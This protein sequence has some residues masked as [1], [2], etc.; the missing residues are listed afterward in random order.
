MK[1][2]NTAITNA[3]NQAVELSDKIKY[4]FTEVMPPFTEEVCPIK[5][6]LAPCTD[7]WSL[8]VIFFLGYKKTLRFNQLKRRIHGISGRMLSITLKRLEANGIVERKVFAEVPPRV[9]YQLTEFGEGFSL[10]MINLSQWFVN[11]RKESA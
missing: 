9:E 11:Q 8:F 7:K 5:D 4:F 3:D 1:P 6:V 2:S 10:Q